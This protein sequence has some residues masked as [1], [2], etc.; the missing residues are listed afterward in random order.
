MLFL[1]ENGIHG[2]AFGLQQGEIVFGEPVA[3]GLRTWL[4]KERFR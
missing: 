4:M 3:A 1:A 2:Q